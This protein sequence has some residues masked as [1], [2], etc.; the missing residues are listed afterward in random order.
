[1]INAVFAA[2]PCARFAAKL[3]LIK[4]AGRTRGDRVGESPTVSER[5]ELSNLIVRKEG[6]SAKYAAR[7]GR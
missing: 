4:G 5:G 1:M 7:Q 6:A 2:R 3:A